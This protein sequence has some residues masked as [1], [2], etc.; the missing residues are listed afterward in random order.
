M[1]ITRKFA[2]HKAGSK[3]TCFNSLYIIW[4]SVLIHLHDSTQKNRILFLSARHDVCQMLLKR[5]AKQP[6]EGKGF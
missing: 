4:P 5:T 3:L 2:L 6:N 1:G